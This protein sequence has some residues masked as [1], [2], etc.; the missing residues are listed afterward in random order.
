MEKKIGKKVKITYEL[1]YS[2]TEIKGLSD[3]DIIRQAEK[4][5]VSGSGSQDYEI[6]NEGEDWD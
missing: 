5:A 4:D 1:E 2:A 3:N 6:K